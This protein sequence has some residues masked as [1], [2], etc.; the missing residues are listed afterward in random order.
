MPILGFSFQLRTE[1]TF[2]VICMQDY[3]LSYLEE[4][5]QKFYEM[6]GITHPSQLDRDVFAENLDIRIHYLQME[7][8]RYSRDNMHTIIL[9]SR[10]EP[11][12]Q[13]ADFGHEL[14]HILHHVGDQTRMSN[15][16]KELQE[17]QANNFMYH[18]CVPTFMLLKVDFPELRSAAIEYVADLFK[19]TCEFAAKRL[20]IFERNLND[21]RF[22]RSLT[23]RI[24][25]NG[26]IAV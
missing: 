1:H 8:R 3:K 10:L 7:S 19:V 15:L 20:E 24:Q 23:K 25:S 22:H 14:K 6:I 16:F 18:F 4:E 12:E 26:G 5:I 13:W 11:R 9:D 17:R 2:E 21:Q